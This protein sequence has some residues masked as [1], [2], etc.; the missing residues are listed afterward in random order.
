MI[1]FLAR[2]KFRFDLGV[3]FM[4]VVNLALLSITASAHLAPLAGIRARWVALGL[5]VVVGVSVWTLGYVLERA[6]F[7]DALQDVAN[8]KNRMLKDVKDALTP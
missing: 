2:Q 7:P 5:V 1:T 8:E 6:K 4:I 3:S